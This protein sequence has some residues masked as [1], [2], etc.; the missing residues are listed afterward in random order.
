MK[1]GEASLQPLALERGRS[2]NER[3]PLSAAYAA[4][5]LAGVAQRRASYG[6]GGMTEILNRQ[7]IVSMG[8]DFEGYG[9]DAASIGDLIAYLKIKYKIGE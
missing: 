1:M 7:P 4:D 6:G 9:K 3:Q 2:E 8:E 5:A